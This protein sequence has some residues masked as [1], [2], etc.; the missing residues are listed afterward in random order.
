MHLKLDSLACIERNK[1]QHFVSYDDLALLTTFNSRRCR[2]IYK[3]IRFY[4][5][6]ELDENFNENPSFNIKDPFPI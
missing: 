1:G 6:F 2:M 3:I 4:H 5:N